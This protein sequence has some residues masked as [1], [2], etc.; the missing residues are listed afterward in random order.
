M[1]TILKR[2]F[3]FL[4]QN[5]DLLFFSLLL[6]LVSLDL[7]LLTLR[8]RTDDGSSIL[9]KINYVFLCLWLLTRVLSFFIKPTEKI[10]D[11]LINNKQNVILFSLLI[12]IA[13]LSF[14]NVIITSV[15]DGGRVVLSF[16]FYNSYLLFIFAIVFIYLIV[17]MQKQKVT[18]YIVVFFAI[19]I[20]LVFV[21]GFLSGRGRHWAGYSEWNDL[22]FN[23][24]NPNLTAMI[25]IAIEMILIYAFFLFNTKIMR[26][27]V[28]ALCGCLGIF[29]YLTSSRNGLF[30]LGL[31]LLLIF[32]LKLS[33][34]Y[35]KKHFMTNKG[36]V[37]FFLLLP[38]FFSSLY[39]IIYRFSNGDIIFTGEY[40]FKSLGSRFGIWRTGYVLIESSPLFG[41]YFKAGDGTG[42]FQYH[43]SLINIAVGY[44]LPVLILV[45]AFLFIAIK[46]AISKKQLTFNQIIALILLLSSYQLGI[47]EAA[48]FCSGLGTYVLGFSFFALIQYPHDKNLFVEKAAF[49]QIPYEK[50][51]RPVLYINSVINGSTGKIVGFLHETN[52]SK[53]I[54]SRI[55]F[56]RGDECCD[57]NYYVKSSINFF[58][59]LSQVFSHIFKNPYGFS[60]LSTYQI[61]S[62]IKS[63]NPSVVHLHCLNDNYVNIYI[64]SRFLGK[65][66]IPTILTH[67]AFFMFIGNCGGYPFN[68]CNNY[69]N[70]CK[71]CPY[72]KTALGK[73]LA[74]VAFQRMK[75]A[76]SFFDNNH[77]ASVSVSPWLLK[78][79]SKSP[80]FEN[81]DN[82]CIINGKVENDER[83][84][85]SGY[86]PLLSLHGYKK[87]LF[88]TSSLTNPLK[89]AFFLK[90]LSSLLPENYRII[91]ASLDKGNATDSSKIVFTN[92]SKE[93]LSYLYSHCDTTIILSKMETYSMPVMESLI[94]GTPVVGFL[95][96]GPESITISHFSLFS[97]YGNL[98]K[99]VDNIVLMNDR[100][101]DRA[102]IVKEA[103]AKYSSEVFYEQYFN[104]YKSMR[105][106]SAGFNEIDI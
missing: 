69:E 61:I 67:H 43:N 4:K 60:Y 9:M 14:F 90:N 8:I 52:I 34:S 94:K 1:K 20:A 18:N 68:G 42:A 10:K 73:F 93:E 30:S 57:S 82:I 77:F 84:L 46:P 62:T 99:L 96:G 28:L 80:I 37:F 13:L 100:I 15:R 22:D 45:I 92:P 25:L 59:R 78:C 35:N 75:Y 86:A 95:S 48:F 31:S 3:G 44:G 26:L 5:Y 72:F 101:F 38:L 83:P 76:I 63:I 12:S 49:L 41:S 70:G 36:L 16:E 39:F 81:K 17:T 58:V 40:S 91:V 32:I 29:I 11:R 51:N 66:N 33:Y 47:F 6:F 79:V 65:N 27:F 50:P 7:S 89:G 74:K 102:T 71:K 104:L 98:N 23:F 2:F 64:L 87:L 56:G 105:V 54:D 85:L 21:F 55:I 103:N 53:G 19:F 97:E 88:V 106:Y 24:S